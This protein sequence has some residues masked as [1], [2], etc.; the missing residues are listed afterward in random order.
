MKTSHISTLAFAILFSSSVMAQ[1][2]NKPVSETVQSEVK[3]DTLSETLQQYLVLKLNLDGPKPKIDTVSILYNK[4][5]GELE[6]LNDPSVPMRYIKTDPDYYRLFVPLTYYNSPIAEY[7]TMHWKFKEP[8]VTPSLSSQLLPPYDTLQFSKAER[9]S[10]LVNVALMDLYLNHPNL[11]VNT[12]D[13][14][15]SRKLYHGDKKIEVPKTEVKS[16]FRAEK[17]E[18]NVGEAEMVISKPNWWVTGGNG[19]LQITQNYISDNWY[20]G[21]ESNNAV[22]ANLQLFAN[23]NDREKVQFENLFEAKLGFNSSPSDEYHKYL[24]NTDQLR[25]YSKLGIQAANNWY[26]TITGEF[27]TQFVKGYKANSEELVAAFLAPADVIVSVGMDYK[28]KK[29]K[30][31]LSVF[32]SPLTYNL[33]YIG[34]K[35][36]DETKFGLDKGKC[37]KN[38]F[39]AQVQPTISWTIIP[40]IVV[41]SRLN[42]LT[43]YKWVRVEWEN[44]FNFVLN[45]YLSTKLFVHARFDDSAKPTTGSSYFQLKELLSFGLNYKW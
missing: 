17:V 43:N 23:Y 18:D 40:S 13:H 20:K 1:K 28:L 9:A 21:G 35:N 42:Y 29:K 19:S 12:E 8:F 39:G 7:S 34:N 25:L 44:T 10:R 45:R 31:N 4:Y 24:V 33:R 22:M 16:L 5:I 37:S 41:D 38:D 2:T 11:V 6:Y 36:V 3:A 32:M 15:M 30:F 26:Y 27:K 14:I